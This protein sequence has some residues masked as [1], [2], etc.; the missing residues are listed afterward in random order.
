MTMTRPIGYVYRIRLFDMHSEYPICT[1]MYCV[2]FVC[3][4]IY[5]YVSASII[6]IYVS[7]CM[8]LYTLVCILTHLYVFMCICIYL[9]V[10]V[11]IAAPLDAHDARSVVEIEYPVFPFS[12]GNS[13][14][15]TL[16]LE[17]Y[18][19]VVGNLRYFHATKHSP[20]RKLYFNRFN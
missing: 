14:T 3:S 7:I 16:R 18:Q 10:S 13:A 1:F 15:P 6:F 2:Y 4:C 11:F 19:L 9:T 17:N 20:E 5:P 12:N 8:Y